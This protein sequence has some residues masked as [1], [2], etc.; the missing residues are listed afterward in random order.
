MELSFVRMQRKD[1][2][3]VKR[4]RDAAFYEDFL[5]YGVCPG[6]GKSVAHFANAVGEPH[7]YR[8]L[9]WAQGEAVGSIGVQEMGEGRYFLSCLCVVP[10]WE[11][12]GV[13]RAALH[14]L[15]REFPDA[16]HWALETPADKVRNH[17]F[18]AG[19][20]YKITQYLRDGTVD[21]VRMER[22]VLKGTAYGN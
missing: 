13:G 7:A 19:H 5:R 15:D 2:Q 11:H 8:Y 20:G 14:F 9:I 17:R 12:Q 1:A 16:V 21:I 6:Y 22:D 18:Y 10:Q 3:T 4:V